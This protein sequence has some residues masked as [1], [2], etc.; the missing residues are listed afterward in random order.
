MNTP[1]SAA[2]SKVGGRPLS[3]SLLHIQKQCM[4]HALIPLV[5][6]PGEADSETIDSRSRSGHTM[7][8]ND[9]IGCDGETGE[10]LPKALCYS[11]LVAPP[12]YKT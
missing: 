3:L 11:N 5:G 7:Q 8:D 9:G 2:C 1:Y 12:L 6:R 4:D 10:L